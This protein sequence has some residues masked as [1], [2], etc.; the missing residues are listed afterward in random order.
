[1]KQTQTQVTHHTVS[2]CTQT[3]KYQYLLKLLCIINGQSGFILTWKDV[4]VLKEEYS[5]PTATH[6]LNKYWF[7]LWYQ[8]SLLRTAGTRKHLKCSAPHVA[9]RTE[10]ANHFSSFQ[11]HFFTVYTKSS[12]DLHSSTTASFEWME[13]V[14]RFVDVKES[15]RRIRGWEQPQ[16]SQPCVS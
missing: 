7:L 3:D 13:R 14:W 5:F 1:M 6:C 9:K 4:F 2:F 8:S 15:E 11:A 16:R 12:G 10:L